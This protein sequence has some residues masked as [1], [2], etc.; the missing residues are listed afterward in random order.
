MPSS[1]EVCG[2]EAGVAHQ[3]ADIG[4][5]FRDVSGLHRQ[6]ILYRR[7]A[8]LLLQKRHHMHQFF[9][10]LIADIVD[11]RRRAAGLRPSAGM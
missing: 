11:P 10:M 2:P 1:M 9:R 5:G 7:A 8:Q 4:E 3:I 6:H